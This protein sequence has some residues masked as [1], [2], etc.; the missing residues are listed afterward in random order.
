L[1]TTIHDAEE[2]C[3]AARDAGKTLAVGYSTRFRDEVPLLH[4]L[5]RTQYFGNVRRFHYQE[6]TI[7][8]WSPA[9]GYIA[10]RNAAGGG[11]LTVVGTH[12]L[13]R[14]LYWFGYPESCSL[15]DDGK[16]GPE[17][18]C[19][20][21]FQFNTWGTRFEG[22]LLLSK[23]VQLKP[24]LVIDTEQGDIVFPMGR[25]PLYFQP[26][27]N[28]GLRMVVGPRGPR[29]FSLSKDDF[30]LEL[31]NFVDA[32]RGRASPLVD[33]DQA[34]QSVRLLDELYRSRSPLPESWAATREKAVI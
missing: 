14:M 19:L 12:F 34:L 1:A 32:C 11:V 22:T 15:L 17:A 25:S 18:H 33:G 28:P 30:Q 21:R 16:N 2:I 23:I 13:D 6:G 26:R 5:L 8:G 24:G 7:G 3:H 9:S 31:E 10:D 20:A 29:I 27:D 4:E